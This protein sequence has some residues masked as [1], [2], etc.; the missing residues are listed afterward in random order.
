MHPLLLLE[1]APVPARL[2]GAFR[3]LQ[4]A[5]RPRSD[6][7][8]AEHAARVHPSILR[9]LWPHFLFLRRI[10]IVIVI[11][12]RH[13]PPPS[14]PPRVRPV[15]GPDRD[16]ALLQYDVAGAGCAREH[17]MLS[18]E[19]FEARVVGDGRRGVGSVD[20]TFQRPALP[21]VARPP[22]LLLA[23]LGAVGD[24]EAARAGLGVGLG[25]DGTPR[26]GPR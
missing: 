11:I 23:A 13:P 25:A 15:V 8:R 19:G 18:V 24:G 5:L 12:Y 10:I 2:E 6:A 16:R 14:R 17:R 21:L 22:V 20:D 3:A 26:S 1:R 9:R 7:R 4:R